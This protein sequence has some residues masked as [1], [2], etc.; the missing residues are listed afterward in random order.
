MVARKQKKTL[1]QLKRERAKRLRAK[2]P[3]L[4]KN[5]SVITSPPGEHKMSEVIVDF[6]APEWNREPPPNEEQL[7]RLL[8]LGMIAWNAA[9]TGGDEGKAIVQAAAA[10]IPDDLRDDFLFIVND[11]IARKE[12]RFADIKRFII[13]Y[14]LTWDPINPHVAIVSALV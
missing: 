4:P 6:L 1:E 8:L 5:V 2:F 10:T 9:V 3:A 12:A 13:D 11:L 7:N 14:K